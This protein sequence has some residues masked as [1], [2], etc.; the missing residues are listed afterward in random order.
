MNEQSNPHLQRWG[1]S[2][3]LGGAAGGIFSLIPLVNLLNLFFFW[4][5]MAG[6]ITV[7]LL[8]KHNLRL[9]IS[10]SAIAGALSGLISGA[11]FSLFSLWIVFSITPEKIDQIVSQSRLFF[12]LSDT[13][14]VQLLESP[15]FKIFAVI[16]LSAFVLFAIIAG[17]VGG[18]LSR[19]IFQRREP[20]SKEGTP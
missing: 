19:Q 5:A 10:E 7:Y 3:W 1:K 6:G 17:T 11:I 14:Y 12:R 9:K 13:D 2:I 4:L 15:Q 8:L 16:A 20:E 18:L